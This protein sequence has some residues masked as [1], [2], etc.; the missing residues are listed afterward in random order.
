VR[1]WIAD[2]GWW[3]A[4]KNRFPPA[5]LV[6]CDGYGYPAVY[7]L[8]AANLF[9]VAYHIA[10]DRIP[11]GPTFSEVG[12]RVVQVDPEFHKVYATCGGTHLQIDTRADPHYDA[13]GLGRFHRLSVP[14]CLGLSSPSAAQPADGLPSSVPPRPVAIG[15][16]WRVGDRWVYLAE[17]GAEIE[18]V[19]LRVEH[20]GAERA[21]FALAYHL[22]GDV[23]EVRERYEL[24]EGQVRIDTQIEGASGACCFRV[25]L[26]HTDGAFRTAPAVRE[27][28]FFV[29]LEAEAC[30]VRW[31]RPEP[32]SICL[33]PEA[34]A[35]RNGIYRVGRVEV[36]G[37]EMT[38]LL[39]LG[40]FNLL[41]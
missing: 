20:E 7:G 37:G 1:P 33:E 8:L 17:M 32:K 34:I 22:R 41:S 13:T 30:R 25:P 26:F 29:G 3:S 36:S 40:Q 38:C 11:E 21:A 14:S 16:G 31:L 12:G 19:T 39:E 6:G 15:P 35:N 10:D 4:L 2:S 24:S 23:S 27:D 28:G 18:D 9:G 5:S